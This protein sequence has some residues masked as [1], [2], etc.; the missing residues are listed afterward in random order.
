[1]QLSSLL[2]HASELVR[3]IR[4]SSQPAD[5]IASDYFR[6]KKY[7]GSTDR[8]FISSLVFY[9][10]RTLLLSEATREALGMDDVTHAAH[11]LMEP[12]ANADLS[13]IETL[14]LHVQI[15][16]QEWLLTSTQRRWPDDAHEVWR[17]M[18]QP[19]PLVLRVNLRRTHRANVIAHLE[20]QGIT[21]EEGKLAPGAIVVHQRVN[22]LQHELYRNGIIEVQDEGSQLVGLAC[23]VEEH[24]AILDAC[25]GAGGKSLHLADIQH[26]RGRITAHDVEWQRLKEVSKRATRAGLRS[27]QVPRSLGKEKY[28][29]VLVDAPCSGL[30]TV[31][32]MPMA[33]WRITPELLQRHANK[34]LKV[35]EQYAPYVADGGVLMYATCSI[36]PE[37]NEDVVCRFVE[38]N[39][40]FATEPIPARQGYLPGSLPG[41]VICP[42][43][44]SVLQVDP[45]H[46]STD[47]LFMARL[48]RV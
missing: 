16:T 19:A 2:G 18:M 48:R 13:F 6:S 22:L 29:L 11:F 34:Q 26:D 17:S 5:S 20:S 14:P 21:C 27:I 47:G 1:M 3:I 9:T 42:A 36:M 31:R 10:L 45:F 24:D 43:E 15:N 46:H 30:G 28:S 37:E 7:L 32:R 12:P 25:A 23:A 4:K 40:D 44:G 39:P 38:R 41:R 33:K 35:L 8:R